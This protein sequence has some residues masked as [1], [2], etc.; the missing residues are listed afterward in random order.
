MSVYKEETPLFLKESIQSVFKQ[1]LIPSEVVLVKDG[2]LTSE[3][4][5]VVEDFQNKHS[6]VMKIVSLKENVGLGKALSLGLLECSSEYVARMDSDDICDERRFELQYNFMIEHPGIDIVG[7]NISEFKDSWDMQVSERIVHENHE[8]IMK[9]MKYRSD[10]NHVTV[11]FKKSAVISSGNYQD[12]KIEDYQLWI[13]MIINGCKF[14]NLKEKLVYVRVGNDMIGRRSGFKYFK[15]EYKLLKQFYAFKL[16]SI[17]EFMLLSF[18]KLIIRSLPK[19]LLSKF[20][21]AFMR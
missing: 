21:L 8:D 20:Y 13:N 2:P 12:F 15:F 10:L 19:K 11:M 6:S 14:H 3:L 1:S 17:W 7:A 16:I 18:L 5:D 9:T 4:N